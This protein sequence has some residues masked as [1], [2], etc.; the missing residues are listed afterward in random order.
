MSVTAL[1]VRPSPLPLWRI[2][3]KDGEG[4]CFETRRAERPWEFDPLILRYNTLKEG[5]DVK[6]KPVDIIAIIATLSVSF[7]LV[8]T[9]VGTIVRGEP[10]T[11]EKAKIVGTLVSSFIAIVSMYVGSRI[12]G[13]S[14]D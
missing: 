7:I 2:K 11:D 10:L 6:L 9:V 12:K 8:A 3:P 5:S 1:R 13:G 14:D 4:T